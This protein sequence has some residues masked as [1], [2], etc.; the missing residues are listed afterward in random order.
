MKEEEELEAEIMRM[1]KKKVSCPDDAG[2][3]IHL[4]R[5]RKEAKCNVLKCCRMYSCMRVH[6]MSFTYNYFQYKIP[7]RHLS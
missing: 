2:N 1:K 4:E 6:Q 7:K 5:R 3:R